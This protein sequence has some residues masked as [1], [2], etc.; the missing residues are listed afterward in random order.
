MK[1][2]R[3]NYKG[4]CGQCGAFGKL[5]FWEEGKANGVLRLRCSQCLMVSDVPLKK[6]LKSG[7]VLTEEEFNRRKEALSKVLDYDPASTYWVGQKIR[8]PRFKDSGEVKKKE[9]TSGNHKMI[10]VEFEKK[11]TKRLVEGYENF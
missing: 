3:V 6:I 10:V 7:R 2:Q 5:T 4:I 1:R 11:G 8:H 9:R